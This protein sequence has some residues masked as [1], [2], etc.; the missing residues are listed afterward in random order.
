MLTYT[1]T[2]IIL[3]YISYKM[4]DFAFAPKWYFEFQLIRI[5]RIVLLIYIKAENLLISF[6]FMINFKCSYWDISLLFV[7]YLRERCSVVY[8]MNYI[9]LNLFFLILFIGI[10]QS[11]E[12]LSYVS[13]FTAFRSWNNQNTVFL[14]FLLQWKYVF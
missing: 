10:K 12:S 13:D 14:E 2:M 7:Q 1:N 6:Y 4:K 9:A 3:I 11:L 8:D 5:H